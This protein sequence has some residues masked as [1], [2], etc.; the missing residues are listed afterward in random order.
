MALP[1]GGGSLRGSTVLA[2]LLSMAFA[3]TL[4]SSA[5]VLG[6]G[7]LGN[8]SKTRHGRRHGR[9][10]TELSFSGGSALVAGGGGLGLRRRG[11]R[12]KVLSLVWF[13]ILGLVGS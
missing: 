9:A 4:P 1:S 11:Y 12:A 10:T 3:R 5:F 7:A 13:V 8:T 6:N 2:L